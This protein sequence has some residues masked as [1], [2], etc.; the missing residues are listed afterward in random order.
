MTTTGQ[1]DAAQTTAAQHPQNLRHKTGTIDRFAV[2]H[3]LDRLAVIH[4]LDRS[5]GIHCIVPAP[6]NSHNSARLIHMHSF[7]RS[8]NV[9]HPRHRDPGRSAKDLN[10]TYWRKTIIDA[11]HPECFAAFRQSLLLSPPHT[12][13]RFREL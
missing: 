9:S 13:R 4:C 2:I 12:S 10:L 7:H 3:W 5:A 1:T 11:T 6:L 8:N